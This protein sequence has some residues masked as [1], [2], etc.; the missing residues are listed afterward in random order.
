MTHASAPLQHA[1]TIRSAVPGGDHIYSI[2]ALPDLLYLLD[3]EGFGRI[4]LFD[5]ILDREE[6]RIGR[7]MLILARTT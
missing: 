2:S 7:R 1:V 5:S 3:Q 4:E 6:G